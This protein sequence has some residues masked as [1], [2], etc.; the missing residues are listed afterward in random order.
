MRGLNGDVGACMGLLREMEGKLG[1]GGVGL[2]KG[3]GFGMGMGEFLGVQM[4][5][6]KVKEF[7]KEKGRVEGLVTGLEEGIRGYLRTIGRE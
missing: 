1:K 4:S 3:I 5:G 2:G 7:Y 6:A